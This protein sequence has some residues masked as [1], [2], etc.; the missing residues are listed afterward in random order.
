MAIA[1]RCVIKTPCA[2][3]QYCRH[4][5]A[6]AAHCTATALSHLLTGAPQARCLG[7]VLLKYSFCQH[8]SKIRCAHRPRLLSARPIGFMD[9]PI[10]W[11][12][13]AIL[14][15]CSAWLP[16]HVHIVKRLLPYYPVVKVNEV[17]ESACWRISVY[18][19]LGSHEVFGAVFRPS[20]TNRCIAL[21]RR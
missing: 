9:T 12:R 21:C 2:P 5:A 19:A 16:T 13:A 7:V 11:S 3:L 8:I 15:T 6:I 4:L 14:D 10:V 17:W 20:T 18:I 1:A